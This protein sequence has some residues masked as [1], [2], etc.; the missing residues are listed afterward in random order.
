M[1]W[2]V[3]KAALFLTLAV[4]VGRF[5]AQRSFAYVAKLRVAGALLAVCI[6]FC[7]A[8]ATLSGLAGLAPIVGRLRGR[9][10]FGRG[11]LPAVHRTWGTSH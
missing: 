7:F 6:C 1:L 8:V 2:I 11:A 10:S 9:H 5:W 4:V 3:V